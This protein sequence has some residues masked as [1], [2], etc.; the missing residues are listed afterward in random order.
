MTTLCSIDRF[1]KFLF[2]TNQ[3]QPHVKLAKPGPAGPLTRCS[4]VTLVCHA[5]QTVYMRATFPFCSEVEYQY[6]GIFLLV[7]CILTRPTGSPKYGV[8]PKNIPRYY[9]LNLLIRYT[10]I[11]ISCYNHPARSNT[12]AFIFKMA[13]APF[14]MFLERRKKKMHLP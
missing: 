7:S 2:L 9:T 14:L 10:Y 11:Y 12:E 3:Q 13:T 4:E 5:T 6:R 8:T 1:D